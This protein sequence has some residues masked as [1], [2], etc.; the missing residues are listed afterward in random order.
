MKTIGYGI[1]ASASLLLG[2]HMISEELP[3]T[4]TQ[5][6]P[7][8][9]VL[10]VPIPKITVGATPAPSPTPK[11]SPTPTPT[12]SPGPTPTP[13]PT[14]TPSAG[15]CGNPLPPAISRMNTKIHIRGPN[16]WTLDTT[17]L[18]RDR[19][20]CAAVG[21]TDGRGECAVRPEGSPDRSACEEYAVGYADDTGRQGPT[22]YRNGQ[23]CDGTACEN[24]P[25]NQ[26][27]L[28]A[29]L[30]GYYEA[31]TKDDVCG[32]VEVDR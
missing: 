30:S 12:P 21:F 32:G 18:V 28:F 17:P 10:T 15:A 8:S 24:H 11:A 27:L 9:P 4:P 26:Y 22:W 7:A 19:D 31:C 6:T 1:V 2:C 13:T 20:Y 3:T 5:T 14:P 25:D 23:L 29:N 16:H